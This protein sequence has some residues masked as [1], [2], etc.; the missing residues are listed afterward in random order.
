MNAKTNVDRQ[1]LRQLQE[2]LV[3]KAQSGRQRTEHRCQKS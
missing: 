3:I 2:M 1:A